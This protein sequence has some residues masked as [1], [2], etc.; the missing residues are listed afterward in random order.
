MLHEKINLK[1]TN[2]YQIIHKRTQ[3]GLYV[4]SGSND[5]KGE[6]AY[7]ANQDPG[8]L[9]QVWMIVAVDPDRKPNLFEIVHAR[10]TLVLECLRPGMIVRFIEGTEKN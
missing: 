3:M 7:L 2:Y 5:F 8:S 1:N 9:G 6:K 4:T 10:S